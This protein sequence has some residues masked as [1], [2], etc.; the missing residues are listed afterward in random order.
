MASEGDCGNRQ[1]VI[2]DIYSGHSAMTHLLTTNC[3]GTI[4]NIIWCFAGHECSQLTPYTPEHHTEQNGPVMMIAVG[5]GE[6][7]PKKSVV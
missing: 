1:A 2:S 3:T 4:F 7:P 5:G 6:E